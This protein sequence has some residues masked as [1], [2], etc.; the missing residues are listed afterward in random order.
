MARWQA[1]AQGRPASRP[2]LGCDDDDDDE[3]ERHERDV[4]GRVAHAVENA[5]RALAD[6]ALEDEK[7]DREGRDRRDQHRAGG[8]VLGELRVRVEGGRRHVDHALDRG[9]QHLC[10][11]DERDGEH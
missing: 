2:R 6:R 1:A 11:E 4:R 3:E 5:R 7:P 9:V 8:D 10:D